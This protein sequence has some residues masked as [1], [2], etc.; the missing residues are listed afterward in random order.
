[1]PP[2]EDEQYE[3]Y[4]KALKAFSEPV[5]IR[6]FDIG[7]DKPA[8]FLKL[9]PEENPFLGV[10]GV[11]LYQQEKELFLT[12]VRALLRAAPHGDL[13]VMIPMI[14]TDSE[15]T[16]I[17]EAFEEGRSQLDEK[18]V[19]YGR[20]SLG[21][22]VEVPSA[23]LQAKAMSTRLDFF[24]IGTNDLT[25]YALAADRTNG[26][27]DH[28]SDPFHPAVLQLCRMTAEAG[29]ARGISVS[30]CG[31]AAADPLAAK[32][33]VEMGINK[34]SVAGP[35]VNLTKAELAS[36]DPAQLAGLA[37]AVAPATDGPEVR[38]LGADFFA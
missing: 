18:G 17:L 28:L 6:T 9:P 12:Q 22:M 35:D 19:P 27:V 25:Q 4:A 21:A 1:M 20:I 3:V 26:A 33:F 23:A 29:I 11:R 13:W 37:A 38:R 31:L 32:L 2:S 5:V 34:L 16:F 15:L 36:V 14:A 10:R 30:V 8:S 7:G 24:S